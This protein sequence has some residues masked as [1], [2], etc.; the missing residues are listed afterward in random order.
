[1][2]TTVTID[3]KLMERARELTGID[4][5]S[6][7]LRAGL[8]SLIRVESARRLAALGGSDPDAT[9]APRRRGTAA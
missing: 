8:E 5:R 2:R 1:M 7:L 9:A 4:E 6:V 3:D